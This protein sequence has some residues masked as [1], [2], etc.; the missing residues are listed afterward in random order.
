MI[1]VY[2]TRSAEDVPVTLARLLGLE[3]NAAYRMTAEHDGP[4]PCERYRRALR[5]ELSDVEAYRRR[6][7]VE[8][9]APVKKKSPVRRV[10]HGADFERARFE[11]LNGGRKGVIG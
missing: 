3:K 5:V 6:A 10:D 2:S 9:P 7:R 1:P 4:I 8:P 11:V